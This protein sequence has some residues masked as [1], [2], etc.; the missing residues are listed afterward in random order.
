[1]FGLEND[2]DENKEFTFELEEELK[3]ASKHKDIIALV[4]KRI[5]KIKDTLRGGASKEVFDQYGLL[6]HG[7]TSLLKVTTRIPAAK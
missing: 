3:K 1:M 7:Y 4:E 5:Q 2:K 6:L